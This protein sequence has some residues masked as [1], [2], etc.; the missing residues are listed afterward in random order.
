MN[1]RPGWIQLLYKR[2]NAEWALHT[3][4]LLSFYQH[5]VAEE[6]DTQPDGREQLRQVALSELNSHDPHYVAM[7]LLFLGVVGQLD[8]IPA[9]ESSVDHPTELVQKAA[10][11]SLFELKR[12]TRST[13]ISGD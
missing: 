13:R 2:H 9:V 3:A 6:A 10:Q 1:D 12:K 4:F 7:S 8:D 11:A 5:L